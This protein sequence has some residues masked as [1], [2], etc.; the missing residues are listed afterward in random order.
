M[1]QHEELQNAAL[2]EL[3]EGCKPEPEDHEDGHKQDESGEGSGVLPFDLSLADL[4]LTSEEV[5]LEGLVEELE[6]WGDHEVVRDILSKGTDV[7]EHV[8]EVDTRLRQVELDS[9]QDYIHESDNLVE[10][11]QQIKACDTILEEMEDLLGGFQSDLGNISTEIKT[12]QEQSLT[13]SIKLRNR[14]TAEAELG[15]FVEGLTVPPRLVTDILDRDVSEDYLTYLVALRHRLE[16]CSNNELARK[17]AALQ[18]VEPELDRLRL[19]ATGRVREAL[20]QKFNLLRRPKTNY[21]ILQ[22]SVLLK[23]KSFAAFLKDHGPEVFTEVRA[24]Y[25]DTMSRIYRRQFGAYLSSLL[26]VNAEVASSADLIGAEETAVTGLF[27]RARD[28]ITRPDRVSVFALGGREAV[29]THLDATPPLVSHTLAA[30]GTRYPYEVLFRSANKML[31]D[32]ACHEFLFCNEFWQGD[33][34]IFRDVYE[35]VLSF[36]EES[37]ETMLE[38]CYDAIGLLLMIRINYEHQ[39]IMQKRCVPCLDSYIDKINLLL[40]PRLKAVADAHI[41]SMRTGNHRN[42]WSEDVHAHY[43]ARRYAEFTASMLSLNADY[44]D[45]QIDHILERLRAAACELLLRVA[46]LFP[47]NKQ[48][49]I[50]LVNNYDMVL[51]V[52]K[53]AGV[54]ADGK[55]DR[56]NTSGVFEEL[57]AAQ[58]HAFVEAELAGHFGP[59]ISF[60]KAAEQAQQA[61]KGGKAPVNLAEAK[62]LMAD[63]ASRW[64][65]VIEHMHRDAVTN[66]GSLQRGIEILQR[67]LSQ[68][69]IYYTRMTGAEGVLM[70]CGPEGA[71]LCK[72]A[73][74]HPAFIYEI[75]MK[76][77]L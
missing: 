62:S 28:A 2:S 77:K 65:A 22:Q 15:Q 8:R 10:L 20:L 27:A 58:K 57:L 36:M 63:F 43:V 53:E 1:V 13:M 16:F 54:G 17:A 46:H 50:F 37:L 64:K 60:V 67:T 31:M 72:G 26:R 32:A 59:F 4:D 14:K 21:Q 71:E 12:L 45:P 66:F 38:G 40:W 61:S 39:L 34:T 51:T 29:L 47:A 52:L 5:D 55:P 7:R 24:A 49:T 23:F 19:K 35:S 11:H 41:A 18:D 33:T 76:L 68:L 3:L 70:K 69:L 25:V 48:H 44:G 75:K 56:C 9:I 6:L 73:I 42:L 30:A 74:S